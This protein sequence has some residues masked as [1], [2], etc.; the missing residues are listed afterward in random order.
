MR[1]CDRLYEDMVDVQLREIRPPEA[2][3]IHGHILVKLALTES[4]DLA[5]LA[6]FNKP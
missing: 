2:I 5:L 6:A 4:A 3:T 1:Y